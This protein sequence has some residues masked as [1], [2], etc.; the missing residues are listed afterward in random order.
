MATVTVALVEEKLVR[1]EKTDP[2][3]KRMADW[4]TRQRITFER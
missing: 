1:S 3:E 4:L 2:G